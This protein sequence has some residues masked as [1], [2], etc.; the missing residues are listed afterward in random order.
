MQRLSIAHSLRLALVALT[1]ALAAIAA[2]GVASLYNSRQSYE[3]KLEQT[4]SLATAAANLAGAGIAEEEVLRDA[5]GPQAAAAGAQ[6]ATAYAT[7]ANTARTLAA[8]DPTSEHLVKAQIA[9]ENRA[10]TLATNNQLPAATAASG[11][12]ATAR[13]LA[14]ELQARQT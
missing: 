6:V 8:N 4:S 10:R 2:L 1:L 9:A 11:P 7:A 12:L 5:R 13:A 3:N 14:T